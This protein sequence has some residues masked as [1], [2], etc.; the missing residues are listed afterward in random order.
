[1]LNQQLSEQLAK[2]VSESK[3]NLEAA[4]AALGHQLGQAMTNAM[5]SEEAVMGF[6]L[7]AGDNASS[8]GNVAFGEGVTGSSAEYDG[9]G[10]YKIFNT[11]ARILLENYGIMD[12]KIVAIEPK[13]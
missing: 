9:F 6:L 11:R 8:D 4:G 2:S 5:T 12:W 1:M 10:T 13:Q 7:Q 3:S